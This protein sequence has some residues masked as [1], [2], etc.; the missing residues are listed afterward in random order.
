MTATP[1]NHGAAA[2][3]WTVHKRDGS[4]F[5]T[6]EGWDQRYAD[7]T[8]VAEQAA[9][10]SASPNHTLLYRGQ[11]SID[12]ID[13]VFTIGQKARPLYHLGDRA[14]LERR[15]SRMATDR[16]WFGQLAGAFVGSRLGENSTVTFEQL[17]ERFDTRE[18]PGRILLAQVLLEA[19]QY[20]NCQLTGKEWRDFLFLLSA[21]TNAERAAMYALQNDPGKAFVLEYVPPHG[22]NLARSVTHF[23]SEYAALGLGDTFPDGDSEY[24]IRYAMLPHFLLGYTRLD[25]QGRGPPC[26]Y[27]ATYVPNPVYTNGSAT[28]DNPP[29]LNAAQEE[30][31]RKTMPGIAW[32]VNYG[33]GARSGWGQIH[34][35]GG[36]EP[37]DPP[38]PVERMEGSTTRVARPSR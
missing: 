18:E 34:T 21:T 37:L 33:A 28:L 10:A 5:A 32:V 1:A 15:L 27:R 16:A 31:F 35:P 12:H 17:L 20:R 14:K 24:L 8:R 9:A 36:T 2:A 23:R 13:D 30:V 19:L 22:R 11:K 26:S 25:R 7:H 4:V 3:A 38:M 6:V 29:D